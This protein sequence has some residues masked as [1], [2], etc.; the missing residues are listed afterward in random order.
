MEKRMIVVA[1]D[2]GF[3]TFASLTCSNGNTP[4]LIKG[5]ALKSINAYY[6]EQRSLAIK[7]GNIKRIKNLDKNRTGKVNNFFSSA[8][9]IIIKYC[10]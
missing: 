4:W 8:I 3:G 7:S 9:R 1:I 10:C 6:N 2:M 5:G